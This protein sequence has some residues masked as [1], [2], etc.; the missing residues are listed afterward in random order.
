MLVLGARHWR[1]EA[2]FPARLWE[3]TQKGCVRALALQLCHVAP[4]LT[5]LDQS[6]LP[7]RKR[8]SFLSSG[9]WAPPQRACTP[10]DLKS[11]WD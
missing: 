9:L 8:I 3:I 5:C 1:G 4:G 6:C 10:E 2:C 11:P 7:H